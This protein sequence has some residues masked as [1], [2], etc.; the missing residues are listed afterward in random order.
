MVL[1]LSLIFSG[2]YQASFAGPGEELPTEQSVDLSRYM[3]RWFEIKALPQKFQ[4]GCFATTADYSLKQ[5][6]KVKVVNSCR[7]GS[8]DGELTIAEGRGWVVDKKTNAKLKVSFQWPFAGDYWILALDNDYEY[9]MVGAP[10]RKSLWILARSTDYDAGIVASM[11]ETAEWYGFD[12]SAM[13][14]TVHQ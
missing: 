3:G 13:N 4:Q 8:L 2:H 5:N 10:D 12:T 9:A 6:G 11:L 14:W 1:L 7:R